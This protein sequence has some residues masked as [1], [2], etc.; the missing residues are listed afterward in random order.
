MKKIIITYGAISG[1]LVTAMMVYSS[2]MMSTSSDFKP[3]EIFGYTTMVVAFAFIFVGVKQFRDKHNGGIISFKQAFK[4]GFFI[5][6]IA[7]VMYTIVW[8]F[9]YHFIFP[10]FMEKYIAFVM[11]EAKQS[12]LSEA[13]LQTKLH[14]MNSMKEWY[15]NPIL[16]ILMTLME[17]LPMGILF[18][19]VSAVIF[20]RNT[21]KTT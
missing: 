14:K 4:I 1:A 8:L 20:K 17:I 6:L 19:L 13:D 2:Y 12:G 7:S 5:A 9:E 16:M 18:A 11:K 15:K 21:P 3:S 10:D